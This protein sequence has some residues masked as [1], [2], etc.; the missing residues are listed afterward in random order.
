MTNLELAVINNYI[1]WLE[2]PTN[3]KIKLKLNTLKASYLLKLWQK[4]KNVD[5]ETAIKEMGNLIIQVIYDGGD[6]KHENNN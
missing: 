2:T 6:K 3:R 4:E 5:K 1:E